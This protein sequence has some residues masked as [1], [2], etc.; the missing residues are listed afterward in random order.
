MKQKKDQIIRTLQFLRNGLI[1]NVFYFNYKV[2][3]SIPFHSRSF[4]HNYALNYYYQRTL[5][6]IP[7]CNYVY[8]IFFFLSVLFFKPSSF[9]LSI[10]LMIPLFTN[11]TGIFLPTCLCGPCCK[12]RYTVSYCHRIDCFRSGTVSVTKHRHFG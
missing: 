9:K 1:E 10:L 2:F 4:Y 11:G 8:F 7:Q 3:P 6:I 12:D 5:V